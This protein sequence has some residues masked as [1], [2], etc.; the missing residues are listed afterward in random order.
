MQAA[1]YM[2]VNNEKILVLCRQKKF[3]RQLKIRENG[4]DGGH[5][6]D[7]EVA[8]GGNTALLSKLKDGEVIE[9]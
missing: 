2:I 1:G 4:K 8:L 7:E 5:F 3:T 6:F 9:L